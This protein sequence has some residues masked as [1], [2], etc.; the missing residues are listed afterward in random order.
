MN[1]M[2]ETSENERALVIKWSIDGKPLREI[3]SLIGKSHGFIKKLLQKYRRT[4]CVANIPRRGRKEILSA[5]ARRKISKEKSTVKRPE[6]CIIDI[7][8]GGK[9]FSRNCQTCSS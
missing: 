5:T 4:G 9:N 7:R 2:R 3:A 6:A 1:S 8:N